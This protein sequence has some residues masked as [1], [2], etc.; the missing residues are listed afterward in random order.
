MCQCIEYNDWLQK[1]ICYLLF[2][3]EQVALEKMEKSQE[4]VDS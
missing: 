2:K 1:S 3:N 4:V